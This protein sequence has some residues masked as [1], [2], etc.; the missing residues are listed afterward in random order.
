M[1]FSYREKFPSLLQR[2]AFSRGV[3]WSLL[4]AMFWLVAAASHS[5]FVGKWGLRDENPRF[6]IEVMLEAKAEKPFVYR[7]LAPMIANLVARMAPK[8]LQQYIISRV[9]FGEVFARATSIWNP[10]YLF[11]YITVYY[12]AFLSL[13]LSLWVL[14]KILLDA[15]VGPAAAV[16]APVSFMLAF[17]YLQTS[18]GYFYDSI[19]LAF[20][21]LGFLLAYRGR[22]WA[23]ILIVLPATLNKESYFFFLPTLYPLLRCNFSRKK[24]LTAISLALLVAGTVNVW[25]KLRFSDLPGSVAQFHWAENIQHY[26]NPN[27]YL[28]TEVT[29]GIIGPKGMFLGTLLVILGILLRGWSLCPSEIRQHLSI[30]VA[31]NLPLFLILCTTGELRNL[32]LLFVGFVIVVA[33][34]LDND[35]WGTNKSAPDRGVPRTGS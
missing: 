22:S 32:S 5:G 29:Y 30:A 14:R 31:I 8:E 19:E 25:T 15:G 33:F 20:L 24:A 27:Y 12:L 35:N 3:S 6:G 4:C 23:L 17:P 16:M 28:R 13:F 26:L 11:R 2:M 21:S 7:Q 10:R 9:W 1:D 34:V 18:G